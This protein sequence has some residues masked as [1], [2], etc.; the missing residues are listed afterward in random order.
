MEFPTG[1][2][3]QRFKRPFLMRGFIMEK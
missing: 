2:S 3:A 1:F